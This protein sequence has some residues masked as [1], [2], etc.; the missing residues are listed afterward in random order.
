MK[1]YK[2]QRRQMVKLQIRRRG[3]R[4]PR[5]LEAMELVPRHHFVPK[6]YSDCAY[7]DN[8]ISI[9]KGQTISQPYMVALMTECL[10]PKPGDRILEIGTGSGYQTAI[11]AELAQEVYSIERIPE[12]AEKARERLA[13]LGYSNVFIRSGDGTIGFKEKAPYDGILVAAGSPRVPDPLVEQLEIGGC[14]VIPVGSSSHQSIYTIS[15]DEQGLHKTEGAGCIFVP[16]IGA[17][18][19]EN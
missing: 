19:W 4:N 12:L 15:R 5:I 10:G 13:Q 11:L 18:G 8:P 14:L 2:E 17:H 6:D 9:G 7:E 3:V 1:D 16:L